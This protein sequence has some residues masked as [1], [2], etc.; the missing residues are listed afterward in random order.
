MNSCFFC[1]IYR[2]EEN[3]SLAKPFDM[4]FQLLQPALFVQDRV[5]WM[6]WKPDLSSLAS[7][8]RSQQSKTL[9]MLQ[10]CWTASQLA[11]FDFNKMDI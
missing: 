11:F 4:L 7:F 5:E 9:L 2:L 8:S 3:I 10:P 6:C 1:D